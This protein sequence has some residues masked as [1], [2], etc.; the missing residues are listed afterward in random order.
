M[1]IQKVSKAEIVE[2]ARQVF[3]KRG[4]HHTSMNDIAEATG[5]QK[6]SLYHHFSS[7]EA[8]MIAAVENFQTK[9]REGALAATQN[10]ALNTEQKYF[11]EWIDAVTE[12]LSEVYAEEG[13]RKIAKESIAAI[14]GAVMM[15]Q[16]FD[17][18][19]F[20]TRVHEGLRRRVAQDILEREAV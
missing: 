10:D 16:I 18:P 14:E 4:Y 20:L 7:K 9:F 1:P 2:T 19:S 15:M 5:L 11:N 13:A 6:G 17:D 8:L 12:I 3:T